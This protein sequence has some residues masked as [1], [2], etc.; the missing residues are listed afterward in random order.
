MPT[1]DTIVWDGKDF[2]YKP[3]DDL[4]VSPDLKLH[5]GRDIGD[6]DPIT[7]EVLSTKLWNINEEHGDTI[8]RVSGSP[9]VVDAYDFNTSITTEL[10]EPFLFAPYIQYF[11]GAAEYTVK[12]TLENR[13][14]NPGVRRGDVFISN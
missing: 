2:P 13:S 9:V 14:A 12:Y 5:R 4:R 3:D 1:S 10:G 6:L 11:G 8:H 7:F